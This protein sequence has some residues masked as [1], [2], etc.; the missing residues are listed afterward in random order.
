MSL[1]LP[2]PILPWWRR[3]DREE[4]ASDPVSASEISAGGETSRLRKEVL[5]YLPSSSSPPR[6]SGFADFNGDRFSDFVDDGLVDFFGLETSDSE[7]GCRRPST[8][9]LSGLSRADLVGSVGDPA[10]PRGASFFSGGRAGFKPK[11]PNGARGALNNYEVKGTSYNNN[12]DGKN[13]EKT[14]IIRILFM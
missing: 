12:C 4:D 5:L 1:L 9:F 8:G 13:Q 2:S 3:G 14:N 7:G 11:P 10:A 6:P